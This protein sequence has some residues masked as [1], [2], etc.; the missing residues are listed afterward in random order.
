MSSS[1]EASKSV[2]L[3]HQQ[4]VN[5]P[6]TLATDP[7]SRGIVDYEDDSLEY[8]GKPKGKARVAQL[9]SIVCAGFA[10]ISD[11]YQNN[12][13]TMSNVVFTKMYPHVY[14]STLKTRVSNALLV[15]EI[16]GQLVI[17]LTCDYMGRKWAI[18]TTTLM[19][20]IGGILATAAHGHTTL[21]MFWMIIVARGIVGFG[22]GGEYPASSTAASE[23]AN[24]AIDRKR[25][26]TTFVLVTNLPLSFGGPFCLIIFLIVWSAAGGLNHLNTI[27]RVCF[28]IGCVWPLSVFY[29]RLR[30]ATSKLYKKGAMKSKVPYWLAVK[31]YW[32]ELIGTAGCW[33]LYDFV[34]FPNGIFSGTIISS[35][36]SDHS[37]IKLTA[38]WNLLLG[39]IAIP[40]VFVGAF[41]CEYIG[42]KY[43][44]MLGFSGYLVFGLII[45]CAYNKIK[46]IV[47]LFIIFYGL[48]QSMGNLGPG[49]MLGLISS[50]CYATGMRGTFY[51][52]SAA[53]GKA[54]AAI[55][56]QVFTPIQTHLGKEW[57]FIIAAIIGV[58]GVAM[59]FFFVPHLK[60]EDLNNVDLAFAEYLRQQGW[61]G[62]FGEHGDADA[63][64][65]REIAA[66]QAYVHDTEHS[67]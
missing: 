41:L 46:D 44:M 60:D 11:G 34:T 22:T 57:T 5:S 67:K 9:F 4:S 56:T 31:F 52:F 18:V 42:R 66:D 37:D 29:F 8:Q 3:V 15:G 58:V 12:L 36:I 26:G 30:M 39:I 32:R 62:H 61:S 48:M 64:M 45:G 6:L 2:G 1:P 51:G 49:D 59:T 47:P 21:G 38:E 63:E 40:G 19:I 10:L 50:E 43:T 16:I 35:V 33:F 28:G 23:A 13:M 17:G 53:V 27:W 14:N 65:D 54:G 25:R 20:V 7:D 24:E 55:G